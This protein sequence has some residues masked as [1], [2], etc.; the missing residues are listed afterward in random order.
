MVNANFHIVTPA[1]MATF[2]Q[3]SFPYER[4]VSI[5]RHILTHLSDHLSNVGPGLSTYLF[6]TTILSVLSHVL[7]SVTCSRIH[8]LI[9]S[10][11]KCSTTALEFTRSFVGIKEM[12]TFQCMHTNF[13]N[14]P[15]ILNFKWL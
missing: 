11:A 2:N 6:S 1:V 13:S 7:V 12:P 5:F 15:S 3:R 9:A 14:A 8:A 10:P 4:P